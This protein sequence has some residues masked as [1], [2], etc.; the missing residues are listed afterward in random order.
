MHAI[1]GIYEEAAGFHLSRKVLRA[2]VF[3]MEQTEE[4]SCKSDGVYYETWLLSE[5]AGFP[6]HAFS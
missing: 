6:H 4:T 1:Q 2:D 3:L 5:N